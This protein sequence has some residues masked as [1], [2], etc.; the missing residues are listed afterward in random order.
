MGRN[1]IQF[2]KGLS[3]PDFHKL[4]G[5]EAQCEEALAQMRW[6]RGFRCPR[7]G[8]ASHGLVYG[9]RLKRYQCRHCG[10]QAT[11]TAGTIME[12]TKLPLTIWFLAFYL[13]GQAK[14]S[15]SSLQLSRQLGVAYNTAWMLHSKI[16]RAMSER[17]EC[18]VLQGKVQMDDAYLGGER[19]GGKAG[20]G[21]ENKVP[22]VAAI[23]L[24]AEG[25]PIHAKISPVPGFTSEA[26]ADWARQNLSSSCSVLSDGLACFRSVV[27]AGCSRTAAVTGGR[28]PNE[29][30]QFRW[31]NILLG[32]LKTSFSGTFHAFNFEKY[33]KRYLGGFCFRFNRRFKMAA[34]TERIAN[35][36]CVCKP[37]P[38]R[39]LRVA[40]LYA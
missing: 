21:S 14:T 26:I 18:Y 3:V 16:L 40:E 34:M 31:I 37:C 22:I 2:Q 30:P 38:E 10:H 8:G 33:A 12:S 25:H 11:V 17:D 20:R 19:P 24:N 27:A 9:R 35:A 6:P 13:I 23:S 36:V 7:C 32:N 15:I 39:A 29:L 1:A 28:H 5:T 4:Y